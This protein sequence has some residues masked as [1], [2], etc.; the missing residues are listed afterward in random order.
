MTKTLLGISVSVL[1][2]FALCLRFTVL[3]LVVWLICI[4]LGVK[5]MLERHV[6]KNPLVQHRALVFFLHSGRLSDSVGC[7]RVKTSKREKLYR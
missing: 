5:S 1:R 7:G 3:S 2:S 6:F 4:D